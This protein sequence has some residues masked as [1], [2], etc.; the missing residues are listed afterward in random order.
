MPEDFPIKSQPSFSRL[1]VHMIIVMVPSCINFVEKDRIP[2]F[3]KLIMRCGGVRFFHG[4]IISIST[5]VNTSSNSSALS[6]IFL[7]PM[8]SNYTYVRPLCIII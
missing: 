7:S 1:N 3:Q 2:S 4:L 8:D 5:L 6:L